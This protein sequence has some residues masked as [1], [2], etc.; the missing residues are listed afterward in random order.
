MLAFGAS[1]WFAA[2]SHV[3]GA[4]LARRALEIG[5][6]AGHAPDIDLRATGVRVRTWTADVSG[7]TDEDVALAQAVSAAAEQLGL[8]ADPSVLQSVQ[9]TIDTA[10]KELVTG[11]W[12]A[13]LGYDLVG[14][15]FLVDALRRDPS[16]WFQDMDVVRPL[17]NR[18][19]LDVAVAPELTRQRIAAVESAGGLEMRRSGFHVAF[20]DAEGNEV[21]VVPLEPEGDLADNAECADWRL[22]FA[23]M[24]HYPTTNEMVAADLATTVAAIADMVGVELLIAVR[25]TGV[26]IGSGKD[27][28]QDARFADLAARVQAAARRLGLRADPAPLRFVQ[29]GIDAVDVPAVRAFWSAVLGYELDSRPDV[30]DIFDPRQLTVA[31]FFQPMSSDDTQ[32]SAQRNRTHVDLFVPDDQ[33]AARIA[34]GIAAGGRVVYDAEAPDWWTL[35]DPEGNEVDIAVAVGRAERSAA[36]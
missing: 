10:D 15:D 14:E 21:D 5:A 35:A 13:T 16:V 8:A 3:A 7:L 36:R 12:Q 23:A 24:V 28:W 32:R 9:L 25:P 27:R 33:A 11:F 20:A 29:V 6:A 30:T 1:A 2:S 22:A 18:V 26:T 31:V 17:R 4:E 19:H 34:A